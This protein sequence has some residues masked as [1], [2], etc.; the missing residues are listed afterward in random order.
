MRHTIA[1]LPL[2][3]L[4]AALGAGCAPSPESSAEA[5]APAQTAAVEPPPAAAEPAARG[6][7][8]PLETRAP[9]AADQEPAIRG[10]TR[11]CGVRSSVAFDVQVV[12]RG[13]EK[14]WAVE[15]LP[16]GGLLVTEKAGR[17]RIVSPSGEVGPS[18]A[19]VPEV[20]ARGQGG[21]L[22]VALSPRF[23]SD[24]TVYWSYSEPREGGNGTSVARGVLSP[25]G[26]R[27]SDV[28]VILRTRPTYSNNAHFGSRLAFG[29]DGN[30]FVTTGDRSNRE[31]RPQAQ[32]LDSHLGKTLR[33]TP[34]GRPAPGNPFI[35]RQGALPEI[36]SL[37]HR[38]IQSA[39]VDPQGRLWTV[40]HGTRGGDELNLV[41]AGKNYGWPLATYGVEYRG[42]TISSAA[43]TAATTRPGTEQPVYYWDPVVAPSGMEIYTGDA[44]PAWRGSVFVGGLASMRLVRLELEDGRVTGEE[45]LLADRNK[46]IRD[47]RQ[48]PD[49]ALYVVTDE[50][51]AELW[52]IAPRG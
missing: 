9:N 43:G 23:A 10:Q 25:D 7:C 48:G 12:A 47:V 2:A 4:A 40:E 31:T 33:I 29:P 32:Q 49:G 50:E 27:L 38:N 30:L 11:A 8:T 19:G 24:R 41:E 46:R 42:G 22:D 5:A 14:P 20:D 16:G 39:A 28:R 51:N 21:L 17:M 34:E 44:F 52:R 36:W 6:Q 3:A 37:G 45:H 26:T 13:L 35:G 18:I 15:P 1:L